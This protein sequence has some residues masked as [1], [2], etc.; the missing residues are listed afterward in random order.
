M[1]PRRLSAAEAIGTIGPGA[2][3]GLGPACGEPTTLVAELAAQAAR[4][5]G[6]QVHVGLHLGG[7]PFL[8]TDTGS[9]LSLATWLPTP[10]LW[11]VAAEDRVEIIPLRWSEIPS[12]LSARGV[13][14]ALIQVAPP[15]RSGRYSLGMSTSYTADLARLAD[16][17]IAEVSEETP[18]THGPSLGWDEIDVLC[19]AEVPARRLGP[20]IPEPV[21]EA[22]AARLA[23]LIPEHAVVQAG[24]GVVP[25]LL[26]RELG[27]RQM[28]FSAFGLATEELVSASLVPIEP[29]GPS[30]I[31]GEALGS[32]TLAEYLHDNPAVAFRPS[33]YTHDPRI[34]GGLRRFVSVNSALQVDLSGQVNAEHLNG[35]QVSGPGGGPDFVEGARL[36]PESRS[37]IALPSAAAAGRVSRIVPRLEGP[38][39]LP[40][41]VART[42]VTEYGIAELFGR[43]LRERAEALI[44][45]AHPAH[46][47]TLRADLEDGNHVPA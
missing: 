35:R 22:I 2:R 40:R 15:D 41:S 44:E 4:L 26:V 21:A 23:D 36:A 11:D 8:A 29:G 37:I 3:I 20:L 38:V 12:A 17:V 46:R 30:A 43:S 24:V 6:S 13:T 14:V 16:L 7:Y 45:I 42:V 28:P 47:D 10:D 33:S 27:R 25:R 9:D 39:T 34:S 32:R 19:D 18:T 5:R 1:K 31:V